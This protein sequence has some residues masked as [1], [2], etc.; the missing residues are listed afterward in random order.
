VKTPRFAAV[1]VFYPP[2]GGAIAAVVIAAD[3]TFSVVVE[4]RVAKVAE[5]PEYRPGHF[6]DRELPA[7]RAVLASTGSVDLLVVDGFVQLDPLGRP[8]LGAY[9]HAEFAV[10]VIGVAKTPFHTA[11]HAIEIRRSAARRPLYVT[12]AGIPAPDAAQLV[13]NM[14]GRYR[15][16]DAL[17]RVDTLTRGKQSQ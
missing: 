2:G 7:L 16:P 11:T 4:E 8:G 17:R 13:A 9:A 10:P 1:D 3:E 5:V 12:A 15:M 6:A 14:A